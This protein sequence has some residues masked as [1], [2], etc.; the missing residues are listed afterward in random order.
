V[1]QQGELAVQTIDTRYLVQSLGFGPVVPPKEIRLDP[2]P[3][4]TELYKRRN[5][6]ERLIGRIKPL[7]RVSTWYNKTDLMLSAFVSVAFIADQ[8]R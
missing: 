4:D 5:E 2:W 1:Q 3:F 8:L 6:I 7:R